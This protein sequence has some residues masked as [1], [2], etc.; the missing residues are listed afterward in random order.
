MIR[1]PGIAGQVEAHGDGGSY[2]GIDSQRVAAVARTGEAG[3]TVVD[4]LNGVGAARVAGGQGVADG[5]GAVGDV[6]ASGGADDVAVAVKDLERHTAFAD[7]ARR[8][9]HGRVE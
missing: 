2:R 9:G 1:R 6:A 5:G 4:G 3:R 7:R 8:A